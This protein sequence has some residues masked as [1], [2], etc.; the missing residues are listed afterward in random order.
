MRTLLIALM[1]TLATQAGAGITDENFKLSTIAEVDVKLIDNATG[2]CWTNLREV[3]EYAEEKL[4][5][6]GA[7][8]VNPREWFPFADMRIYRLSITVGGRRYFNDGSG[9]CVGSVIIELYTYAQVNDYFH[10]SV[11]GNAFFN[12][13]D[14]TNFNRSA[15]EVLSGFINGFK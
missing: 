1:M 14:P 5:M 10:Q 15:I 7:N 11:I 2:A 12:T 9:N 13:S 6:K 8:V 3:R 4:R